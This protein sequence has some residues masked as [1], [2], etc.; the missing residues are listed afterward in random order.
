M[1]D[2]YR[3]SAAPCKRAA[4]R[5]PAIASPRS[6]APNTALPATNT[7]APARAASAIVSGPI[8][9][10]DLERDVEP[11]LVDPAPQRLDLAQHARD[12]LLAAEAGVHRH[13]EH[14]VDVAEHRLDARRGRRRVQHHARARARLADLVDRAVQVRTRLDVDADRG[15]A[16]AGEVLHIALGLDDHQ[17]HV[18]RQR[19]RS[20]H[21]LD[22][23]TVRS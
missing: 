1:G 15:C 14:L 18:E 13:H 4:L 23:E 8:P 5:R 10:S 7:S 12:E 9:P 2:D 19:G 16:R 3:S 21:R 20:A 11:A 6:R 17:V 22:D